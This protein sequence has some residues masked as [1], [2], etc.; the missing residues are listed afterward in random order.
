MSSVSSRGEK[1]HE[2]K[3]NAIYPVGSDCMSAVPPRDEGWKD[4]KMGKPNPAQRL[5]SFKTRL[6]HSLGIKQKLFV[7][8]LQGKHTN[9][10]THCVV[11]RLVFVPTEKSLLA[12]RRVTPEA[13]NRFHVA[14]AIRV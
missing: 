2:G 12:G 13:D 11:C 3:L 10:I 9:P 1:A 8:L 14:D 7:F 6:L 4:M 5:E